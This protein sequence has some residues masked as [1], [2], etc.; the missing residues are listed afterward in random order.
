MEL[1]VSLL[2]A[3]RVE[4]K[5]FFVHH[6]L[7]QPLFQLEVVKLP[8]KRRI[9]VWLVLNVVEVLEVGMRQALLNGPSFCWFKNQHFVE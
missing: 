9:R 2:D 7:H 3:I 6:R 8:V 5:C 4:F 1:L